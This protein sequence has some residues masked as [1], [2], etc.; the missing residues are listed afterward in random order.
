[1]RLTR[2]NQRA[3]HWRQVLAL[4]CLLLLAATSSCAP[5]QPELAGLYIAGNDSYIMLQQD[6]TFQTSSGIHGAWQMKENRVELRRTLGTDFAQ[7]E[8]L[9]LRWRGTLYVRK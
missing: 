3:S 1:M 9:D 7:I 5:N 8:G 6:G 4:T 2:K